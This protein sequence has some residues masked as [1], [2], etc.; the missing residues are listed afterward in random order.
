M[1]HSMSGT[2]KLVGFMPWL[3]LTKPVGVSGFNFVPFLD[4]SGAVAAPLAG[5]RDAFPII[6]S[7]YQDAQERPL[8]NCVVVTDQSAQHPDEAWNLP[9]ARADAVRWASSL[10]FLASWASNEYF[11]PA[12]FYVNDT[13]FQLYFQRFTEPADSVS[14]SYRKRDGRVL[15]GGPR[16]GEI[17][18]TMPLHC[19]SCRFQVEVDF[20]ASLD[21]AEA[22]GSPVVEG[23]KTVLPLVRLANTDDDVMTLDAEAT[24]MAF[25]LEQY[26]QADDASDLA[27]KFDALFSVYGKTTARAAQARRPGIHPDPRHT[28]AQLGWSV[29]KMWMREFHKYRS[30]IAHGKSLSG[31]TWGWSPF[32]H[33]VMA[34]FVF[35]LVVKL[36]L[37]E[38]GHYSLSREDEIRCRAVDALLSQTDWASGGGSG[39]NT[40]WCSI[41]RERKRD[42]RI[43]A[44]VKRAAA[45]PKAGG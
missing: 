25:A 37:A 19:S 17:H 14:L 1:E 28:Q 18:F 24:L 11:T 30:A 35:P 32:E 33:L 39:M 20:L 8:Q 12:G 10:L 5:L 26:L 15:Y 21:A 6:L 45:A 44:A 2:Q 13:S 40:R 27:G 43:S 7:S 38:E 4:G 31:R 9:E 23:L 34:A 42:V 3:Q 41:I 29:A 16:H 22:A 36:R